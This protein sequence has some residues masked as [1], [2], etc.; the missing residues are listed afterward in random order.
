ME[1]ISENGIFYSRKIFK[2]LLLEVYQ[3][4]D[5]LIG[6]INYLFAKDESTRQT[7]SFFFLFNKDNMQ[8]LLS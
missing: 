5:F 1:Q 8:N 4:L 6:Y 2:I 7:K 3:K